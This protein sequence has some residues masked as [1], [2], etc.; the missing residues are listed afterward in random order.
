MSVSGL[1]PVLEERRFNKTM[2]LKNQLTRNLKQRKGYSMRNV[3]VT[4]VAVLLLIAV[5]APAQAEELTS[6]NVGLT[7]PCTD[8]QNTTSAPLLPQGETQDIQPYEDHTWGGD[9]DDVDYGAWMHWWGYYMCMLYWDE[10]CPN[11]HI[12]IF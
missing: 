1:S 3:F 5:V 10:S 4:A 8:C 12:T 9:P 11:G 6:E 2:Y 7:A